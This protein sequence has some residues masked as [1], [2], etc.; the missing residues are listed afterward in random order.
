MTSRL[1][2]TFSWNIS[3][4]KLIP[5]NAVC[6]AENIEI[7]GSIW[8]L[9]LRQY[10]CFSL[11]EQI[12]RFSYWSRSPLH[13]KSSPRSLCHMNLL[14]YTKTYYQDQCCMFCGKYWN[15]RFN[16]TIMSLWQYDC[17]S[18]EEQIGRFSCWSRSPLHQKSSPR[19]LCHMNLL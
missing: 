3:Y 9:C 13:Q 1:I 2:F 7:L 12:G 15:I 8:R 17:F 18:L 10:E 11:E 6:F 4:L 14:R 5:I 16:L 19:S